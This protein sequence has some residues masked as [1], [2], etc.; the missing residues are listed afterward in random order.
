MWLAAMKWTIIVAQHRIMSNI[1]K[2][3]HNFFTGT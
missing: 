1:M 3:I 2:R